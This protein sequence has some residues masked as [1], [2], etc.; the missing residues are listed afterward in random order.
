MHIQQGCS[1]TWLAVRVIDLLLLLLSSLDSPG[2]TRRWRTRP[3]SWPSRCRGWKSN[4]STT[5]TSWR[6]W[7]RTRR[8]SVGKEWLVVVVIEA[9]TSQLVKGYW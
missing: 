7:L 2:R 5:T 8:L 4:L 3:W 6:P 9:W 1:H